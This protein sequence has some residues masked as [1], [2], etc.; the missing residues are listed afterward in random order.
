LLLKK[1]KLTEFFKKRGHAS[2]KSTKCSKTYDIQSCI[3]KIVFYRKIFINK[4]ISRLGNSGENPPNHP[5]PS[6]MPLNN[7]Y[8]F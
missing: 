7:P 8:T 6:A 1:R 5:Q 3:K 4:L 2:K